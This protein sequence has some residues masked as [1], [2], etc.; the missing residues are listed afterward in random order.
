M[1]L[2]AVIL[3]LLFNQAPAFDREVLPI[4]SDFCFPCHGP[5]AQSRKADLRLDLPETTLRKNDPL[6]VPGKPEESELFTRMGHSEPNKIMPPPKFGKTPS[7]AQRE[8][9]RRWIANGAPWA[10]H[11]AFASPRK[12]SPPIIKNLSWPKQPLDRFVLAGLEL[13]GIKPS[14]EADKATLLRRVTLDLTGLPPTPAEVTSFLADSAPDSYERIVDRLLAS[15][16]YGERMAWDWLDAARYA[17]TNGYQG[18]GERTMWPWRDWVAKAFN[19][20]LPYDTFT[21]WQIAGDLLPDATDET[22]LATGF[23]RNYMI[24]G[25]G[26]RIA[27]ENRIDYLFDQAET[28]GTVWLGLTFNC[29][30]CH[31]HKFDPLPNRDYYRLMAFFNTTSID[32]GGGNPQ[33]PPIL[34]VPD[35][36][37]STSRSVLN[38]AVLDAEK[39]AG[40]IPKDDKKNI[41]TATAKIK[42]LKE[43]LDRLEKSIPK[44][45]VMADIPNPRKTFILKTGLYNQPGEE[46]NPGVPTVLHEFPAGAPT[47]RL[48][49][50][51]WLIAPENPLTSRVTVNRIWTQFFGIGL[52]KTPEDFGAQGERPLQQPLLDHLA[53]TFRD[54]GWNMKQLVS[55]VVTSS[56]YRQS[57]QVSAAT[58]ELD[59][60]NR[61]LARGPRFRLPSWMLRDQ[62]LATSGLLVEKLGGPPVKPYQPE[63]IWEEATFG[64]KKYI[65]DKGDALYRRTVYTF[66][67]RIVGPTEI[68][69]NTPRQVCSVKVYRTNTPLQALLT[70]NDITYVEAARCLA[71]RV[72]LEP[73]TDEVRIRHMHRLVLCREPNARELAIVSTSLD[74]HRRHFRASQKEAQKLVSV[75]ESESDLSIEAPEHAAWTMIAS[76]LYNL[77]ETLNKE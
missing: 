18:D 53:S 13:K 45:M 36:N 9:I 51:R 44:V 3:P 64:N 26:G 1:S 56:T 73:G 67:R 33:T 77:D 35:T 34:A 14:P 75:G 2:F 71:Q 27:E 63:G 22:R 65:Q 58:R 15:P 7:A 52:V 38:K 39:A 19:K 23:S 6:V 68:F 55:A 46:V 37:Q 49:L 54:S 62:S 11:W 28:V 4:F 10:K 30:R 40:L 21:L 59:P 29:C 74:R 76:T 32:G 57:S 31:D 8:T 43:D 50:A 72:L 60:D 48:G 66:W 69:D 47:N 42:A 24:N 12:E 61:L 16:R 20:N 5:D 25:E 41:D 17:D 70:L